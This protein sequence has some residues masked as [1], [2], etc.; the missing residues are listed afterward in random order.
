MP[1]AM[2]TSADQKVCGSD[3]TRVPPG[4]MHGD[5]VTGDD[6]HDRERTQNRPPISQTIEFTK[7]TVRFVTRYGIRAV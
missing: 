7:T 4:R 6:L 3:R 1:R 5:S 2:I